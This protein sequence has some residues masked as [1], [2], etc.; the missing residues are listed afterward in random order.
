MTLTLVMS[1]SLTIGG[2][3]LPDEIKEDSRADVDVVRTGVLRCAAATADEQHGE[4]NA[5]TNAMAS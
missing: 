3:D 2:H 5:A 1:V 4:R